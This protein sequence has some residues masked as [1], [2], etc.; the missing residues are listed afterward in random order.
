MKTRLNFILETIIDVL[1]AK[2][3]P[4]KGPGPEDLARRTPVKGR[5]AADRGGLST[6]GISSGD[7]SSLDPALAQRIMQ[8][9]QNAENEKYRSRFIERKQG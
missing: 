2:D 4:P 6:S 1:E 3:N 7:G 5:R 9:I 8:V